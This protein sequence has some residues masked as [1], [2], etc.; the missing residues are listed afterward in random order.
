MKKRQTRD[1]STAGNEEYQA[2]GYF[3]LPGVFTPDEMDEVRAEFDRLFGDPLMLREDNI[4]AQGRPSFG[5]TP[6]LDRLDPIMDLSPVVAKMTRDERLLNHFEQIFGEPALLFKDKAVRKPPGCFGFDL[7]QDYTSWQELPAPGQH[8]VSAMIAVDPTT[9]ENGAM[10][11]YPGLHGR[12]LRPPEKPCN[13]F[14]KGAGLTDPEHVEGIEPDTIEL[15]IGDVFF[16]SSLVPHY[17]SPNETDR[18]RSTLF[19]AYSPAS[20]GSLYDLY[21]SL[22]Y[23]YLRGDF[24]TAE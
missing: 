17:S 13:I 20:Y 18:P 7:H 14:A 5:G 1:S 24:A 22:F 4:R 2:K 21:Y 11:V 10:R 19:L 8:L 23:S 12:H 15:E 3:K 16:Y 9:S 6:V